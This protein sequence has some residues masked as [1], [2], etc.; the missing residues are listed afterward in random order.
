ML[1]ALYIIAIGLLF[2]GFVGFGVATFYPAPKAP[3][4]LSEP[5][6]P[7]QKSTGSATLNDCQQQQKAFS[8]AEQNYRR[9]LS[10]VYLVLSVAVIV[11]SL[12]GLG[13]LAVIGDGIT[14]G[15]VFLLFVSLGTSFSANNEL[16]RFLSVT[17]GL[18][19][20]LFL[21]YWKF[22]RQQPFPSA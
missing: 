16:L 10:V 18:A 8:S 2:A 3:D 5:I 21:T 22:S 13:K 12:F 6:T 4:C 11:L 1:K 9:N 20:I 7:T 17:A 14:L 15:G 19:V